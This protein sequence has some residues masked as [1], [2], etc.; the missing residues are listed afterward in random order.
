MAELGDWVSYDSDYSAGGDAS[1][2]F[3]FDVS[4]YL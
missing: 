4:R 2:F 3:L 1:P